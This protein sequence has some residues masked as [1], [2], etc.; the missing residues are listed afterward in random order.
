[1]RYA[2]FALLALLPVLPAGAP[3]RAAPDPPPPR[4]RLLFWHRSEIDLITAGTL[5][6]G[7]RIAGIGGD[8]EEFQAGFDPDVPDE[9]GREAERRRAESLARDRLEQWR[10]EGVDVIV[11]MGTQS[12]LLAIDEIE[13]IPV[14]FAA[15]TNPDASGITPRTKFGPTGSNVAGSSSWMDMGR[16]LALFRRAV[17]G[18]R[19]LGVVVS[20]SPPNPVSRAEIEEARKHLPGLDPPLELV[21]REAR[22]PEELSQVAASLDGRIDALWIPID[23]LCYRNVDRLRKALPRT[24][25][26]SSSRQAV[27][28]GASVGFTCDY[29][30]LGYGTAE[31]LREILVEKR[32]PGTIPIFRLRTFELLV[33]LDAAG[34]SLPPEIVASADRILPEPG[35]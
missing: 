23:D 33:N 5:R 13:E 34:K 26:L 29:E 17:P 27:E 25:L 6:R 8:V 24:P 7:L 15:V 32:D 18:L 12:A 16:V 30:L 11:A 3:A 4:I 9:A 31:I 10:D 1:M 20:A 28:N 35:R 2:T 21:V 19:R 14:V 22:S